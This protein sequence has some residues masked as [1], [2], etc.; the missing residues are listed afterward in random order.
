MKSFYVQILTVFLFLIGSVIQL[1]GQLS[2]GGIPL[3][4]DASLKA[5]IPILD[6]VPVPLEELLMVPD[7]H[8]AGKLKYL[9]FARNFN[10]Q[11]NPKNHGYWISHRNGYK[12]WLV[13]IRSKGAYSIGLIFSKY[14]LEGNA[15]LFIYNENRSKVL[16]AYT[17]FNN[18]TSG[19]LPVSHVPGEC[20]YIQ[21]EVPWEQTEYGELVIGEVTH[22]YKPLY[23]DKLSRDGRYGLSDACNIDINCNEGA[24]WQDIKRSVCRI[25]TNGNKY[26]TGTLVNTTDEYQEPYILTAAHCIGSQGEADKSVF[27]FNYES[28]IC[29]GPDG[30]TNHTISGSLLIATGDTLGD[31][32]NLDSLDFSLVKLSISPPD[33]FR[34]YLAGWSRK[35][36]PPLQTATIHHPHGDVK[37]ISFDWDPPETSY[38]TSDYYYEYVRYSHWRILQWD[39]ATT[40]MG[41]SGAPLFDQDHRI[42]GLL[43]GGEANCDSSV[44]DYFTKLDYAWNYYNSPLK[45]LKTWLDP[46]NTGTTVLD[47]LD[48]TN[49][50]EIYNQN[51]VSIYPNPGTGKYL[52]RINNSYSDD[53]MINVYSIAGEMIFSDKL[54]YTGLYELNLANYSPG[55]YIVRLIF[56]DGIHTNKIIHQP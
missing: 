22:A 35:S 29:D 3:E 21:L 16:G 12:I 53:L 28:E 14:R 52:I 39:L 46:L 49:R 32:L 54:S 40:E 1:W 5:T 41:S 11:V 4:T 34:V 38:H 51:Q 25:V 47:G 24:A 19:I 17:S 43:T 8:E 36:S 10:V 18:K 31:K 45:H 26:C 9:Y 48:L 42:V 23:S 33:S 44:N 6:I 7:D 20:I 50:T 37:K 13:G 30:S 27:V 55:L 56:P 15:R 2:Q